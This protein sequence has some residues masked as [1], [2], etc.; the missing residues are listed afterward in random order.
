[1]ADRD[2]SRYRIMASYVLT[3]NMN[4][5]ECIEWQINYGYQKFHKFIIKIQKNTPENAILFIFNS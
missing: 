1:M 2:L 3:L 5:D 4:D